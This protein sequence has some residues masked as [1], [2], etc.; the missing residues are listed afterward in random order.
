MRPIL[1]FRPFNY[2]FRKVWYTVRTGRYP[3]SSEKY[4]L[5]DIGAITVGWR[6]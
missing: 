5:I 3:G 6:K 1:R 2:F 4:Y